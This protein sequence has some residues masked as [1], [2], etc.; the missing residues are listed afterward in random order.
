MPLF[1]SFLVQTA[2]PRL[3]SA[4]MANSAIL[5]GE[6]PQSESGSAVVVVVVGVVVVDVVVVL[7]QR[8][9][10]MKHQ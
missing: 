1:F 10:K 9:L 7:K 8:L 6:H 4:L 2:V 5:R 3:P